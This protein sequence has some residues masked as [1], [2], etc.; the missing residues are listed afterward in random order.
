MD[1]QKLEPL[2]PHVN[3]E[4]IGHNGHGKTTLT[5]AILATLVT[6]LRVSLKEKARGITI[7]PAHILQ[8]E[9]ETESRRYQDVRCRDHVDYLKNVFAGAV[10]VM[11][12]VIL[13]VSAAEK[14]GSCQK[15][16]S[17]FYSQSK[18]ECHI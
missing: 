8:I 12:R 15:H 9:Y 10:Q 2:K 18:L 17:K 16:K 6:Y 14:M 11:D 7:T 5:A 13:V 4:T 3:I 1:R